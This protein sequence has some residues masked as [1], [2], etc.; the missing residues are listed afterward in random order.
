MKDSEYQTLNVTVIGSKDPTTLAKAA[1][2]PL[3]VLVSNIGAVVVF[4]AKSSGDVA[5]RPTTA[6]LR[7][8]PN[9]EEI[10][11]IAPKQSLYATCAGLGGRISVSTSEALPGRV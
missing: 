2:V 1:D 10:Y 11:I 7:L 6:S 8:F 5:P 4:I 3:R 9:R